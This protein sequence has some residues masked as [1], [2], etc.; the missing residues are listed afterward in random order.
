VSYDLALER[1][2][3][4]LAADK[5]VKKVRNTSKLLQDSLKIIHTPLGSDPLFPSKGSSLTVQNI[6]ENVN[7]QFVESRAEASILESLQLIKSLQERQSQYQIVTPSE[8]IEE[9][10]DVIV[11]REP[12]DPRQY[13]IQITVLSGALTV[14]NFPNFTIST[15]TN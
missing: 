9:I 7:Q 5:D 12:T 13:N 8:R 11:N 15:R 1:G 4:A 14:V 6:G 2:D 10:Q 3:L